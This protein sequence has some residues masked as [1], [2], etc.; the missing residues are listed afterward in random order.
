MGTL[1]VDTKHL[2]GIKRVPQCNHT[3]GQQY[4]IEEKPSVILYTYIWENMSTDT[5]F[6][7]YVDSVVR[8]DSM[9]RRRKKRLLRTRNSTAVYKKKKRRQLPHTGNSTADTDIK[10]QQLRRT[11]NSGTDTQVVVFLVYFAVC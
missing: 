11:G 2:H 6:L 8:N 3:S 10:K 9:A 7:F 4:N 5:F 1:A